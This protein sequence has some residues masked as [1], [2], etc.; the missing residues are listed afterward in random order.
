VI[1][2][3]LAILAFALALTPIARAAPP[4]AGPAD[5]A[6]PVEAAEKNASADRSDRPWAKGVP[7]EAQKKALTLFDEGNTLFENSDHAAALGKYREA[8]SVWDHPAIRYNVAVTLINLDQ[9]LAAHDNLELSLRYGAAPFDA[10]TYQ[11]ALTYRKLLRG[12]LAEL[13]VRCGESGA[14]VA[15]D[16]ATLFVAPGEA[17][18]W[19]LP[20]LHQLVAR[21]PG[22]LSETRSLSL[23]PGKPAEETLALQDIGTL[24]TRMVRRWPVWKPWAV[25]G[26]G[27]LLAAVAVPILLDAKSNVDAYDAGV[28]SSCPSGCQTGTLQQAVLD[29]RSRAHVEDVVAI[30]L[31]SVGGAVVASGVALAILNLPHAVPAD[32]GTRTAVAPIVGLGQFGVAIAFAR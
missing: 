31:L 27:A 8:L 5:A 26:G 10:E 25:V 30:S 24:P 21:K 7:D 18:R 14:D 23:L 4:V 16:G 32:E 12:Q 19:V 13:R 1:S 20:G 15:L 3:S 22:F 6:S 2:K 11:Q 28:R 9:P 17:S 29:A